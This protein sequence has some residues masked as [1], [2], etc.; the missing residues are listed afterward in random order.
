MPVVRVCLVC[1]REFRV[2]PVVVKRGHGKFCSKECKAEYMKKRVKR[3]CRQCGKEFEVWESGARK[4]AG[5][6]C[7][8]DCHRQYMKSEEG[9]IEISRQMKS[10]WQQFESRQKLSEAIR[11]LWQNPEYR[12]KWRKSNEYRWKSSEFKKRM[13]EIARKAQKSPECRK[14]LSVWM[15]GLWQDLEFRR[16]RSEEARMSW[17]D[18][19]IR[20]KR[21]RRCMEALQ[22]KPNGLEKAVCELLQNYFTNEWR[23]VG[24]GKIVINGFVPDFVHKEENWIIEVNGD[25]WHSLPEVKRRDKKKREVYKKVGYKVLEVWE[26]EVRSDP[27]AVV[28]KVA[29]YFYVGGEDDARSGKAWR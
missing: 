7:S 22:I 25:Y 26:N 28:N 21:V 3:V 11:K 17:R 24:D 1:G 10:V 9:R 29:E 13:A 19:V 12:E 15:K 14:R 5:K 27:M 20:E 18:P 8:A 16:R 4:G 23:Y 2:K 6:F